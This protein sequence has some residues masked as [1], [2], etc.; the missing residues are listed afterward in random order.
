[1]PKNKIVHI[2]V[3]RL[4]AMGDVAM[5]VPVLSALVHQYPYLR[6]TVLTRAF[7]APIFAELPNTTIYEAHLK[8]KHRGL[9]GLWNLYRELKNQRIDVVADLHNVLRTQILRQLFFFSGIPFFRIDKG[10]KE[11]RALTRKRN[12]I[13]LPLKTTHQRYADVFG[14]MGLSVDL[15]N[16]ALLSKK[17][18][19]DIILQLMGPKK[20][21]WL[22]IAP[23]AAFPGKQYPL[24]LMEDIIG[25]IINTKRYKIFLFGGGDKEIRILDGWANTFQQ[26][27]NIAGKL[28]LSEELNLISNLDV[29]LAMDSGNGHLAAIYGVPVITLWG[30]THPYAGFA[31]FGQ[32]NANAL[33][34]DRERYPHIPTSVYGNVH[35]EGYQNAMRTISPNTVMER[36]DSLCGIT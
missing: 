18:P 32:V 27:I 8:G 17:P 11:K 14:R 13:F 20:L 10:R 15:S 23:F 19:S 25:Q 24:D 29:M 31:P 26:T 7:F 21:K 30:I 4:S 35:P 6:I 2:L 12:K 16:I 28:S 36:I 5:T 34:S 9:P 1:V 22:G 33:L 3:I